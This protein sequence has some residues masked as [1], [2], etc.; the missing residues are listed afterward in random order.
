MVQWLIVRVQGL[1]VWGSRFHF[2]GSVFR[3]PGLRFKI[4]GLGFTMFED[5]P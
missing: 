1:R 2:I 5:E 4:M 3:G